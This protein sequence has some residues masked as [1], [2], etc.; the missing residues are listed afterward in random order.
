MPR[1]SKRKTVFQKL[2]IGLDLTSP[3]EAKGIDKVP[4]E[5][6][7]KILTFVPYIQ[8]DLTTPTHTSHHLLDQVDTRF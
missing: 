4:N 8:Q 2:D 5:V 6:L 3:T 7:V 1:K